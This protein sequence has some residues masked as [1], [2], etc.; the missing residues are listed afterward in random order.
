MTEG[1][2]SEVT[3]I[4]EAVFHL[5]EMIVS[6]GG[7]A[8]RSSEAY[9]PASV[10]TS[11]DLVAAGEATLGETLSRQPGVSRPISGPGRADP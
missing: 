11:R 2:T 10:V 8:T 4:V 5:D 6:A 3:V 1:A 7:G 9:Q